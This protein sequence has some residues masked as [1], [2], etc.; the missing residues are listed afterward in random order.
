MNIQT[1]IDQ[2]YPLLQGEKGD[3]QLE[4][5]EGLPEPTRDAILTYTGSGN[6]QIGFVCLV[7][8]V[9]YEIND[10]L[11]DVDLK[12]T[13]I[14]T[15]KDLY[16]NSFP[17]F[18][19]TSPQFDLTMATVHHFKSYMLK[20]NINFFEPLW[21]KHIAINPNLERFW[22][23][24]RLLVEMN[25]SQTVRSTYGTIRQKEKRL[26]KAVEG[27]PILDGKGAATIVRLFHFLE[28]LVT[29]GEFNIIPDEPTKKLIYSL[30]HDEISYDEFI[31]YY[32][33]LDTQ[34]GL[35]Y[36]FEPHTFM[37]EGSYKHLSATVMELDQSDTPEYKELNEIADQALLDVIEEGILQ[38][39]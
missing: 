27:S 29:T 7:G 11:S 37:M 39:L 36:L 28:T 4:F 30:R 12:A 14:P 24:M 31:P 13:F 2:L 16:R 6:R 22:D 21:A 25:I 3:N 5:L 19:V 1:T 34:I 17:T 10:D 38:C 20:G 9:N 23:M 8:S 32:K 33:N 26:N 18:E 35:R 15:L